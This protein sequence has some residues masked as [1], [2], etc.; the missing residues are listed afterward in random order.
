MQFARE[1]DEYGREYVDYEDYDPHYMSSNK[2]VL[3]PEPDPGIFGWRNYNAWD[4]DGNRTN[5]NSYCPYWK[6]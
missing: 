1:Y 5:F 2:Y 3:R 4:E 6:D